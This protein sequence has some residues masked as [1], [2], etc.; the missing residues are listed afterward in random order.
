[1]PGGLIPVDHPPP[2][3][4]VDLHV[5]GATHTTAVFDAG[6]LDALE[7]GIKFVLIDT[8]A[9]VLNRKWSIVIDEIECQSVVEVYGRE[10]S[11]TGFRPADAEKIRQ[12]L[13]SD[14]LILCGH[15]DVIQFDSHW[16]LLSGFRGMTGGLLR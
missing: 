15:H 2:V 8:E 7:N 5:L 1:V 4:R 11:G 12:T 10:W 16:R 14:A 3:L 6:G 9:E 13:G